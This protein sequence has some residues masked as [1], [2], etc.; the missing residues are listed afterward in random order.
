MMAQGIGDPRDG[1][2][3]RDRGRGI[4]VLVAVRL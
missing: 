1:R 3:D 2:Y 4:Y